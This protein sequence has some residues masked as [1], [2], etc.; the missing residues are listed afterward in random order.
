[1]LRVKYSVKIVYTLL[2]AISLI[3]LFSCGGKNVPSDAG[4]GDTAE[5]DSVESTGNE[6]ADSIMDD[7]VIPKT[8]DEYFNDFIYSFTISPRHQKER[9]VF[10]LPYERDGKMTYIQPEQWRFN[11]MYTRQEFYTVFFDKESSL[12]LEKSKDV[13]QVTIEYVDMINERVKDYFFSRKDSQWKLRKMREYSLDEYHERDFILFFDRF[14][15][16][17]LYQMSH[18]TSKIEVSMPDPADD[19][20]TL[21]GMIESEQWPSFRPELPHDCYYNINYGQKMEN[22]KYRMVAL[23]GSSNGF[24]SLLFFRQKGYDEWMLYKMKN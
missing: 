18:I 10:P 8:A 22:K 4:A 15:S 7:A 14:V 13:D 24:L 19:F 11:A 21:A 3:C 16:D 12:D 9:I 23:E 6:P 5:T 2:C 1:M 17:S 20:E